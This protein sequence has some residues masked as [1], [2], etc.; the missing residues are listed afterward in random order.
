MPL[1]ETNA[2]TILFMLIYLILDQQV[3]EKLYEEL[4]V[5]FWRK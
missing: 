1:E 3:Q 4:E 5:N 2:N